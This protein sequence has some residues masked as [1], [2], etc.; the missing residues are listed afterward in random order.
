MRTPQERTIL[1]GDYTVRVLEAGQGEPLLF[2]HNAMGAGLWTEGMDRLAEHFHVFLPDH[3][4]F[5][6]SP[7]PDW[8]RGMDDLIFHYMDVLDILGLQ[9][10][11]YIV[12]AS[13]GGWIGAEF[14][15]FHPERVKNLVLIDAAGLRIPEVPLP[16]VFRI[17]PEALLPL[18]FHDMS[19]AVAVMPKEFS[20][21][22]L[23]Q[24]FHDRTAFARLAWHPYLHDPK[25]PRRLRY[26]TA[27]TLL[28][29]GKQ[30]A[31]IPP[32]Y[33]EEYKRLLPAAQVAYIDACGHDPTVEQPETFAQVAI[34]F[35]RYAQNE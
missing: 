10:P 31:I 15:A 8:L 33:A 26:A 29:W 35:L 19:K 12:G 3:P 14:A 4:G 16:D 9:D 34:D 25:L 20:V 6:P 32:A 23:I 17:A 28:V 5:G 22:T 1:A 24:I 27:P 21:D 18:I 13:L 30:D 7:L 2:L 11:V